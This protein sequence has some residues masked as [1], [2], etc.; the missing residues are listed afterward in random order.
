M[1]RWKYSE[2]S[3]DARY[4]GQLATYSGGG[5][6]YYFNSNKDKTLKTLNELHENVWID[7]AT[8]AVFLDYTLYTPN[9]DYYHSVK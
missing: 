9:I 6:S 8:R 5:F 7:R 4:F 3:N 2:D 1:L